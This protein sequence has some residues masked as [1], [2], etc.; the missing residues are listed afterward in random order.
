M[1]GGFVLGV[2]NDGPA[3]RKDI[4]VGVELIGLEVEAAKRRGDGQSLAVRQV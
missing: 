1:I 3:R 4:V 2:Q